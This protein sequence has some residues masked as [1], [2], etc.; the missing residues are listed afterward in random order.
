MW[1][2]CKK[3]VKTHYV[4]IRDLEHASVTVGQAIREEFL[5][6][7]KFRVHLQLEKS[8]EILL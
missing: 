8:F 3:K 6:K 2:C 4:P 1:R 5:S 7:E